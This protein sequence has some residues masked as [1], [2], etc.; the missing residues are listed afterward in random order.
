[1]NVRAAHAKMGVDVQKG[2]TLTLA[3]AKPLLRGSVAMTH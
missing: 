3:S 2:L 1:M